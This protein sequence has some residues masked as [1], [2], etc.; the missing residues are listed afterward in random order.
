MPGW[1]TR[2]GKARAD[3]SKRG[4]LYLNISNL[5]C[6]LNQMIQA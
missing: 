6:K 5:T 3:Q 1:A 2:L 4:L